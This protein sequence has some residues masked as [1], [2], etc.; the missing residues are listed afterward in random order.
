MARFR[1]FISSVQSEFAIER[2]MLCDYIRQDALLGRLFVPFLFEDLPAED[3]N[4]REAYLSEATRSEVYIGI[5][6]EKYGYEDS[7]GVSPTEREFDAATQNSRCRLVFVKNVAQRHPKERHL[8]AKAEQAVVRK[9]FDSYE[10]LQ[11][12]VYAS[13]V[14]FLEVKEIVRISPFDA[15]IN[16]DAT[17]ED[18]DQE[19]VRSFIN[20]AK[21]KR[22]FK[23]TLEKDGLLAV[24]VSMDLATDDG[25]ITNAAILLFGKNPQHFFRP[26]EVK[27]AQF[28]G[29]DVQKPAPF[30]QV[31]GGTVFE[32]CDQAVS[33][34]MSHIDARIGNHSSQDD[35]VEFELPD[36][37]VHEAI[38]N[39]IIHR[40]YTSNAS[41]QVMLFRDRLEIWNPGRLPEGLTV[42]K[43]KL[44]HKSIPVNPILAYPAYLAG[45]I[46]RLGTGTKDL[47]EACVAKGLKAPEFIEDEDFCTIIWRDASITD[48]KKGGKKD[49]KKELSDRQ[50]IIYTL[51]KENPVLNIADLARKMAVS[52]RTVSR[53]LDALRNLNLI[54]RKD[55]RKGGI[56]VVK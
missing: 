40:D 26:S 50:L 23:L 32:M 34:V 48:G 4:A 8:I 22:N 1:L 14:R 12:A 3:Q 52:P 44:K 49:G 43:L 42:A 30:Y 11:M 36:S 46:E 24:L 9:A 56:W 55:G 28:Y 29:M 35:G 41:V 37:A 18:I 15:S 53:E 20:L 27:C 2:R 7:E 16:V 21:S 47:V 38:V 54:E 39:A 17:F 13:L 19:K 51:L 33:F 31:F 5:F 25:R 6:G 10:Q 45:Y